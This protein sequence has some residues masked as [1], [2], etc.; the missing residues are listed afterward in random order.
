MGAPEHPRAPAAEPVR[1]WYPF[2]FNYEVEVHHYGN[3][4]DGMSGRATKWCRENG[5]E[6]VAVQLDNT[7][8]VHR[9]EMHLLHFMLEEPY[10]V[11]LLPT[12]A[13][14]ERAGEIGYLFKVGHIEGSTRYC[15]ELDEGKLSKSHWL[16]R[17]DFE[18]Y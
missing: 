18:E 9:F 7:N 11:K 3:E 14:G 16:R 17:R 5:Q 10:L 6:V 12:R 15:V 13:V 8:E 4:Y 2:N 1:T